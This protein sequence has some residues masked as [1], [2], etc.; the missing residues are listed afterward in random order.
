MF[1]HSKCKGE[2]I[3]KQNNTSGQSP[4]QTPKQS[5]MQSQKMCEGPITIGVDVGDKT[6]CYC[7][8]NNRC[9]VVKEAS[10]SITK[11]G[12]AQAFGTMK[13]CRI[14]LEVG[15]HSPWVSRLLTSLG[16]EV[17]VANPRQLKLIRRE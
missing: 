17:F 8:L 1:T 6:S 3:L 4:L 14:V 2:S 9:E 10:V 11:K 15:T 7:L 5:P 16:H 12:L 13:R